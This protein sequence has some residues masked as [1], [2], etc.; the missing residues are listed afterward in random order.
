M[1]NVKFV[2]HDNPYGII[3]EIAI[4][5]RNGRIIEPIIITIAA[6]LINKPFTFLNLFVK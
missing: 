1:I 5:L 3:G 4:V 6:I 2:N